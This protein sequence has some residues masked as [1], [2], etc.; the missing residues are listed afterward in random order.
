VPDPIEVW[1]RTLARA[2]HDDPLSEYMLLGGAQ[3]ER[4]QKHFWRGA[5]SHAVRHG[6]E[7]HT[8]DS[9]AVAVWNAPGHWKWSVSDVVRSTPRLMLAMGHRGLATLMG[10]QHI[11]AVHPAEPEHWYL[12]GLGTDPAEQG[13]GH[14]SAAIRPILD[15]CDREVVPAYLESSKEANIPFYERHGFRVTGEVRFGKRGPLI[16]PMWRDPQPDG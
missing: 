1:V 7:I 9:A 11:E 10:L 5:I 3:N 6:G 4:A 12:S 15:R 13:K 16:W 14:G 2:F 8:S